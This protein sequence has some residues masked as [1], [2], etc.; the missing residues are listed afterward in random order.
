MTEIEGKFD[1]EIKLDPIKFDRILKKRAT[2]NNSSSGKVSVPS[3]YIDKEVIVLLPK[4]E[5]RREPK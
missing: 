5:P 3:D 2:K 4:L 1:G